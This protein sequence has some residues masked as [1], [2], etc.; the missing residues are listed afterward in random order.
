MGMKR[1]IIKM[2]DGRIFK[3]LAYY[4]YRRGPIGEWIYD[5]LYHEGLGAGG[6]QVR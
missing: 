4:N 5:N 1:W 3:G 6:V 2:P